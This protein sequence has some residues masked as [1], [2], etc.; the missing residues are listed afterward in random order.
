[1]VTFADDVRTQLTKL[2]RPQLARFA[3]ACA[4][5]MEPVF[6]AFWRSTRPDAYRAWID[7]L[8]SNV[9]ALEPDVTEAVVGAVVA[10]PESA[11]D[12][13]NRPDYYAMRVLGSVVYA[14]QTVAGDDP[15][16]DAVWAAGANL[17]VLGDFDHA[18]GTSL[19]DAEQAAQQQDLD[20]LISGA[21][22]VTADTWRSSDVYARLAAS[23]EEVTRVNDWDLSGRPQS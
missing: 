1:M 10:T 15:V 2:D 5:R 22:D 12:D 3:V 8:W 20:Q 9:D 21:A 19:A 16:Q 23:T 7:E 11:V 18:L 4:T 13:S 17:A 6:A 14:A